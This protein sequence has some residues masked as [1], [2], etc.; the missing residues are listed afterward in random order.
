MQ[1]RTRPKKG[2]SPRSDSRDE[3]ISNIRHEL[4]MGTRH[5]TQFK[6]SYVSGGDWFPKPGEYTI[7]AVFTPLDGGITVQERVAK[8][9]QQEYVRDGY[10]REGI[11]RDAII[12]CTSLATMFFN[13]P[14]GYSF[15][16]LLDTAVFNPTEDISRSNWSCVLLV[17]E[18]AMELVTNET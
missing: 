4:L 5:V 18:N 8:W 14:D 3:I 9:S 17:V 16:G 2:V 13:A 10:Y 6:V 1:L 7:G 11:D 15:Q 12:R